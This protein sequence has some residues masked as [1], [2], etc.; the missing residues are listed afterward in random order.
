METEDDIKES[1]QVFSSLLQLIA[2]FKSQ[3]DYQREVPI[4]N[5]PA[6]LV[7]MW[8]DDHYHP[9]REW[10]KESFAEE[11]RKLMA[12]FNEYYEKRVD[13]LPHTHDVLELQISTVWQEI[14]EKAKDVW[15]KI[16]W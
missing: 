1:R 8:F 16:K 15:A 12:D 10:F 4:A 9:E 13:H 6:E 11:E 2:D 5:V 14:A 3:V 7:C